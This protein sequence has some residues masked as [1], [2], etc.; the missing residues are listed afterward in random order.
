ML[1]MFDEIQDQSIFPKAISPCMLMPQMELCCTYS[2]H[3]N[4]GGSVVLKV[5]VKLVSESLLRDSCTVVK[6]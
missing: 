6:A 2:R 4:S 3:C 5:M 1:S